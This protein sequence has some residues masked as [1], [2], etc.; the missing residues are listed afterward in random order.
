MIKYSIKSNLLFGALF[1]ILVTAV[2]MGIIGIRLTSDFLTNRFHSNFELLAVNL[3]KNAELGVLLNDTM[4]LQRLVD[5]MIEQ[6][7]VKRILIVSKEKSVLAKAEK[8]ISHQDIIKIEMPVLTQSMTEQSM[9]HENIEKN[10][11]IG[12]VHLDYSKE[13][14]DILKNKMTMRFIFFALLL[15]FVS[16]GWY[17]FFSRSIVKTLN[18][19]VDVSRQVSAGSMDV[20]AGGGNYYETKILAS[21]FNDMLASLKEQRIALEKAYAQMAD[22]KSMAKVGRFS[23]M[24]AHEIKNPL[25]IIKGSMNILKKSATSDKMRENMFTY[26]EEEI[27]R[28]NLLV[29][30]FLLYSKPFEPVM[31]QMDMNAFVKKLTAKLDRVDFEKHIKVVEKVEDHNTQVMCDTALM[32]RALNNIFKN[33]FEACSRDDTVELHTRTLDGQWILLIK[34]SGPGID[35]EALENLF[36]PFYTTKAK[37]TG[38]G[39]AIVKDIVILHNGEIN[40]GNNEKKGAFFKIFLPCTELH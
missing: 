39:L 24:V 3:A 17:W 27:N 21:A 38:L 26:Q 40:A 29:E 35:K 13:S 34:D 20:N 12:N 9:I 6:D 18:N 1:S 2:I 37:G 10:D 23:L 32:E 22:Q 16:A 4:M 33:C 11:T 7:D 28:I 30:N 19:L 36:E 31:Q 14:L 8:E 25:S 15:T 5:N